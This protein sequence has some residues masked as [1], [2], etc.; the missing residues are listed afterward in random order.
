MKER[1][2]KLLRETGREGI[3][4]LIAWLNTTDFYEAPASTKFHGA[5]KGGLLSHSLNV[6]DAAKELFAVYGDYHNVMAGISP[7]SVAI[8]ALLH[9]LCKVNFYATEKRNRKNE[10]GQWESY[11]CYTVKEKFRYGG[12]GSKSVFLAQQ[13]IKL[14]PEEA[15]AINCHMGGFSEDPKSVYNAYEEHPFAW[16]IHVA[17]EAAS[18]LFE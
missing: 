17:D 8:A 15:I 18:L 6:Y 9:D 12:H 11:D 7:D 5:N 3:E 16:M 2:E 13:F 4:D 14:T 1:F 10:I